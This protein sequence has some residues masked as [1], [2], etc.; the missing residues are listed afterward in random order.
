MS[1]YTGGVQACSLQA[2]PLK[3]GRPP[4]DST[5][6]AGF[7]AQQTLSAV[8]HSRQSL[9]RHT[10][11]FG[12][13]AAQRTLSVVRHSR[14]D[15]LCD[16]ADNFCCLTR[17]TA[18]IVCYALPDTVCCVIHSR[19]RRHCLLPL[20]SDIICSFPQ[21]IV[22]AASHS[23]HCVML[24]TADNAWFFTADVVWCVSQSHRRDW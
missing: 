18:Q 19:R 2:T 5:A 4:S 1:D 21:Q 16:E 3:A 17:D 12:R 9:L 6:C 15:L 11:D 20:T 23:R 8:A 13:C 10:A 22:S 7:V 14:N 24:D